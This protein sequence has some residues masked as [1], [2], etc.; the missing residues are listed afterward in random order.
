MFILHPSAF[1]LS[2]ACY[3]FAVPPTLARRAFLQAML[4]TGATFLTACASRSILSTSLPST[5]SATPLPGHAPSD[6]IKHIV[7]VIQKNHTF[8][9]LFANFPGADGQSAGPICTDALPSDPPHQHVDALTPDGATTDAS[10]C[11][12]A[13]AAAPNY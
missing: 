2:P 12:Y 4:A 1:I 3:N 10:R 9:S 13:E 7:I 6:L 11:S 5:P 8:D